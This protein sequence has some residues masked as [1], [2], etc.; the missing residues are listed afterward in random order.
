MIL[1]ISLMFLAIPILKNPFFWK[2]LLGDWYFY[3]NFNFL[4]PRIFLNF[5]ISNLFFIIKLKL[6]IIYKFLSYID[7]SII[8]M[9]FLWLRLFLINFKDIFIYTCRTIQLFRM[10]FIITIFTIQEL[11]FILRF[12]YWFLE[13]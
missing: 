1:Y 12:I 13:A 4:F 9:I 2:Y 11:N 6:Q 8:I 5:I 3:N 7:Q 10:Y